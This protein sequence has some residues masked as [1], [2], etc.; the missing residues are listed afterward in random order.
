MMFKFYCAAI[1]A[2]ATFFIGEAAIAQQYP[3]KPIRM[4]VPWSAGSQTDIL[5]RIVGAKMTESL[6]QPVVVENRPGAGGTVGAAVIAVAPP[7]GYSI[8]MQAAAHA[9]SPALYPK[10][11]YDTERDFAGI[12]V[13]GSVPNVLVVA[14]SLG[15]KSV[16]ELI[17]L[18]KKKP[19]DIN[20]ASAGIGGG[21][22]INGELFKSAADINVTHIPHK[23]TPEALISTMTGRVH[24]FFSPM[25]SAISF[26]KEGRLLALAVSTTERSP[27]LPDVPTVAEAGGLPGFDFDLW[28]GLFAPRKTPKPILNQLS[29]EVRR[30]IELPEVKK[31]LLSQ[32][33]SGKWSSPEDFDKFVRIEIDRLGKVVKATGARAD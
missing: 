11:S 5:A 2:A 13:V 21:T 26:L 25:G 12:S 18:A 6:G 32:G 14:P 29:N 27:I 4:M 10:L 1:A 17:A 28:Y 31:L 9:I 16:K 15:I 33:V 7:D 8:M 30:I 19:G 20:F 3:S 24:Y 23:G 22:H